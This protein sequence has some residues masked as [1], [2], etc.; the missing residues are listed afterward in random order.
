[1]ARF[2]EEDKQARPECQE[3]P[4]FRGAFVPPE[5]RPGAGLMVVGEAPGEVEATERGPFKGPSGKVLNGLLTRA[6]S[7]RD[8][9]SVGNS[10][11][12]YLPGN[13]T[14][15]P[16][17]VR[18]CA[19]VLESTIAECR[20]RVLLAVGQIATARLVGERSI[21]QWRGSLFEGREKRVVVGEEEVDGEEVYKSGAKKGQKKKVK[22]EVVVEQAQDGREVVVALHPAALLRS[23]FELYPL[24]LADFKRAVARAND[25]PLIEVGGQIETNAGAL[26]FAGVLENAGDVVLDVETEGKYGKL[27]L[28]GIAANKDYGVSGKPTEGVMNVVR[29][30]MAVGRHVLT[31]HNLGYD[32]RVLRANG[33]DFGGRLFDTM[34]GAHFERPDLPKALD[35]VASRLPGFKYYNWKEAWRTGRQCDPGVYNALDCCWTAAIRDQLHQR[36]HLSGRLGHFENVLM[37]ALPILLELEEEGVEVDR[38]ELCRLRDKQVQEQERLQKAWDE[39]TGGVNFRSSPQLMEF[40]YGKM[41]MKVKIKRKT[42]RPTLDGK[43]LDELF[44]ENPTCEALNVLHQLRHVSQ[45]LST[46]L[47]LPMDGDGRVHPQYNLS[48]TAFGRLSSGGD[49]GMNFQNLPRKGERCKARAPGCQCWNVRRIFKGDGEEMVAVG[50][51]SQIEFRISALLAGE[52]ELIEAFKDPKFDI[53]GQTAKVMGADRDDAKRVVHLVNYGGGPS[54]VMEAVGCSKQKALTWIEAFKAKYA[55]LA[56]WRVGLEE[57]ARRNGWVRNPFGRRMYFRVGSGGK[58][59]G[60]KVIAS[61]PQSTAADMMLGALVRAKEAGLKVRWTV[62]DELGVSCRGKEDVEVLKK[63][64]EV[65]FGELGGWWCPVEVNSGRTWAEAK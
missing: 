39:A 6:G 38:E 1:M 55:K 62:H 43:A 36:L 35:D 17:E 13:P 11:A 50:D 61:V 23:G 56:R 53:H 54:P 52:T 10:V 58:V 12:C 19:G 29:N 37:R 26:A 63:V 8:F 59:D 42:K 16:G 18:R 40:F 27:E 20:P 24:A 31:G 34:H 3:C 44:E 28:V 47:T 48:G 5:I 14:P 60:P 2:S 9:V 41:G 46:F 22:R 65:G 25:K 15:E 51:W 4:R 21:S 64:M 33:I 7:D 32:L 49:E 30:W 45:I 57:E